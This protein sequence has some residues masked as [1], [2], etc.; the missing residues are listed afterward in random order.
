[1]VSNGRFGR[2]RRPQPVARVPPPHRHEIRK[3]AGLAESKVRGL[4]HHSAV[5]VRNPAGTL[6]ENMDLTP[7]RWTLHFPWGRSRVNTANPLAL[8]ERQDEGPRTSAH[9][10]VTSLHA[11]QAPAGAWDRETLMKT[12]LSKSNK[13]VF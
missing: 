10:P 1:M 2:Q 11:H 4:V 6:P 3:P 8:W 13:T 5:T 12:Q 7:S 9:S